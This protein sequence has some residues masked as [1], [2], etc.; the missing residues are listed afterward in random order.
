MSWEMPAVWRFYQEEGV[1]NS[2]T[3]LTQRFELEANGTSRIK[4][5]GCIVERGT[6]NYFS[7][8]RSF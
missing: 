8:T 2:L 4:K 5:M 7:A 6:N 1:E 3:M